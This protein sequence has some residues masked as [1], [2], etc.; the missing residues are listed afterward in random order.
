MVTS[1][2]EVFEVLEEEDHYGKQRGEVEDL[3][4]PTNR[5]TPLQHP[6]FRRL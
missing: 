3:S 4:S 1:C 5:V 6:M 2:F